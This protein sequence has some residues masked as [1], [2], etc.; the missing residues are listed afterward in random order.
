MTASAS[1]VSEATLSDLLPIMERIAT[2]LER[3]APSRP[4]WVT[5]ENN[6]AEAFVWNGNSLHPVTS[7]QGPCLARLCGIEAQKKQVLVNTRQFATGHPANNV[8]LWGARGMGKSSLVKA[9]LREIN[10]QIRSGALR[11]QA[12]LALVEVPRATLSTLPALLDLL[13]PCQRRSILFLD[14]LSFETE[15][16][17]YK[18]LKTLLDG[19]VSGRPENVVVY[20]TSNRRH[21]M[22]RAII[23]NENSTGLLPGET[24]EEKVS[25]SDRFG[26]WLGVHGASQEAYLAIV[27]A[28]AQA[29]GVT[30]P[31]ELL[32][33]RALE[34]SLARGGRSG[35]VAMQFVTALA[36][37]C[38][39]HNA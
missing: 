22:P 19:G 23:E 26:L 34:W 31:K 36:A 3:L 27:H 30:L 9:A 35:R 6:K 5:P 14:D 29:Q 33:K 39:A 28:H 15:D 32:E 38:P 12:P 11:A 18:A 8:L 10:E 37:E 17:D 1:P 2:S 21:L 13:R 4:L 20:A 16:A 25:L 7:L 24:V